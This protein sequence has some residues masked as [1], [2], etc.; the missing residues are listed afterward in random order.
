VSPKFNKENNMAE[1]TK[2]VFKINEKEIEMSVEE[3]KELKCIL[4]DMFGGDKIRVIERYHDWLTTPYTYW[5]LS[6]T[7]NTICLASS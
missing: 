1:I 7:S 4:S 6:G 2:I 5:T 3:A